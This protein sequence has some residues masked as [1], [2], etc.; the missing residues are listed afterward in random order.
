MA[1]E[2]SY[3]NLSGPAK[4]L[5][6]RLAGFQIESLDPQYHEVMLLLETILTRLWR[7]ES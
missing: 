1:T 4:Q 2:I 5:K 6:A 3:A 7:R